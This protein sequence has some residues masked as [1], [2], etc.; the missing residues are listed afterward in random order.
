MPVA[1]SL[2][3]Q[4]VQAVFPAG[5]ET[6][7]YELEMFAVFRNETV[8]KLGG[9]FNRDFWAVDVPRAAQAYPAL[10]H[11]SLALA[12]VQQ[13]VESLVDDDD[14]DDDDHDHDHD[15]DATINEPALAIPRQHYVFALAQ[16]NK[17]IACMAD[18]LRRA[19]PLTYADKEM[20]MLTNV[21]YIG[22]CN[23]LGDLKQ[24]IVHLKNTIDLIGEFRF[25]EDMTAHKSPRGILRY[26]ELLAVLA[27][28]DGQSGDFD[29]VPDRFE[30]EYVISVPSYD[31]FS[32][33]T[34]VY[35]GFLVIMYDGLK[36]LNYTD[37]CTYQARISILSGK[38]EEYRVR[39]ADYESRLLQT[40]LPKADARCIAEIRL[41]LR[42]FD[43]Y[44]GTWACTT[45]AG[46]IKAERQFEVLLDDIQQVLQGR[47]REA[48]EERHRRGP[49]P[50]QEEE[51]PP[52]PSLR[53]RVREFS[54]CV[55]PGALLHE[56]ARVAYT[57]PVRFRT[58]ALMKRFPFKEG[59]LDSGFLAARHEAFTH[60]MLRAPQRTL[61]AQRRG[62]PALRW[63]ADTASGPDGPFDGCRGCECIEGLFVCRD[64][65]VQYF[66][67]EDIN[68]EQ[69]VRLQSRYDRR[70][71]LE[72]EVFDQAEAIVVSCL[73]IFAIFE[74]EA[75]ISKLNL[76]R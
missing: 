30:R 6:G 33:M 60:F 7:G 41:F 59:V 71:G 45:R 36:P 35:L 76:L 55:S 10:W 61:P 3:R 26:P 74:A 66:L 72:G 68:G 37:S 34:E 54:F 17:S 19:D 67:L 75:Y 15:H 1:D 27:Y 25:G 47:Q 16:F 73:V 50:Q 64:H 43:V 11:A 4:P 31:S 49:E 9:A 21:L 23:I 40:G 14:D 62:S 51:A 32:S 8:H 70:Y 63:Y 42:Y 24:A 39:L 53:A 28:I 69:Y 52:A 57:A 29:E 2:T 48:E 44:F 58:Q 5:I 38:L 18:R 46:Y 22:I 13:R 56:I 20:V 12:A 65:R